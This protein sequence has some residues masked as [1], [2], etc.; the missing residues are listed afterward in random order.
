VL[1]FPLFGALI[2]GRPRTPAATAGLD[3]FARRYATV[4]ALGPVVTAL[5]T[6]IAMGRGLQ[7]KW[8]SQFWCFIGLLLIVGW[9]PMIDRVAIR[10][11]VIAWGVLTI[12]LM[13]VQASAQLFRVG[14]GE[15]WATQFPGDRL[16]AIVTETWERETH[17]RLAYVIGD[18]WLG[19]NVIF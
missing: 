4:L 5:V 14:G 12:V 3:P 8:A 2:V 6:S 19:G 18:F 17:Q 1:V 13:G 9:R 11:F 7:T 16:A 10:R 15:R